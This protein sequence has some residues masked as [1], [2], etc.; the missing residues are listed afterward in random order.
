MNTYRKPELLAP[1]GDFLKLEIALAYGA[2][3]VYVGGE[4]YS[5]R[6]NSKNFSLESLEA[7]IGY[8]HG[9]GAKVYVAINSFARNSDIDE[10]PAY[11]KSLGDIGA[12]ALIVSDPGV[13]LL[14]KEFAPSVKLHVS[15]Q[16]NVTNYKTALF[17]Q[18]M[19]ADRIILAREL[20]LNEI[21]EI[22]QKAPGV[23]LEVFIHGAMCISYSGRCLL[24]SYMTGRNSNLGECSHPCRYKYALV[25]EKRPGESFP[26]EEDSDGAYI[27]SSKDLMLARRI[28][29]LVNAG[30]LSLK[31]EGRMKS[32]YYVAATV[33]AYR[34]SLDDYFE[35]KNLY[36]SNKELYV[37]ELRKAG[38]RG[39]TEGFLDGPAGSKSVTYT[40]AIEQDSV[41]VGV[42]KEWKDGYATVEQRNNFKA[43]E[44]LEVLRHGYKNSTLENIELYDTNL[45]PI[46]CAPHPQQL[47]KVKTEPLEPLDILRRPSI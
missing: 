9:K 37:K 35:D 7:A 16:A 32:A 17:W 18:S 45:V 27:M 12:D 20:S 26:I 6:A 10:L 25:E 4:K 38:S 41:F 47:A 21:S 8:A 23:A 44:T 19:G 29:E 39:F 1:A 5:L 42:V 43:G 46:D 15:T 36:E 13:F 3:A 30:V 40:N 22:A 34:Q 14:A 24:S 2:D 11:I 31:I 33:K 28:P